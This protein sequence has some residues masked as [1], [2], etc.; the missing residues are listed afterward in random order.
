MS[1]PC[2]TRSSTLCYSCINGNAKP[3]CET[4]GHANRSTNILYPVE[5]EIDLATV[6]EAGLGC[7]PLI[8]PASCTSIWTRQEAAELGTSCVPDPRLG[9]RIQLVS[10]PQA[11]NPWA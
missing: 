3:P 4:G 10:T 1:L 5:G 11:R 8:L 9:R 7:F 6:A 2:R